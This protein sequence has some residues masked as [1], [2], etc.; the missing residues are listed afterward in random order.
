MKVS[1]WREIGWKDLTAENKVKEEKRFQDIER[2]DMSLSY[3][4]KW[5]EEIY[6][7]VSEHAIAKQKCNK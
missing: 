7:M 3:Q 4:D 5:P 1:I 2:R 6:A